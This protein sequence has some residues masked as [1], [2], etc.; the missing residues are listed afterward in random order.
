MARTNAFFWQLLIWMALWCAAPAAQGG[1]SY[2]NCTN[3]ITSVPA[4]IDTPGTWCFNQD[5]STALTSGN[6]ITVSADDVTL[7]CNDFKLD[8]LA[9]GAATTANGIGGN[10]NRLNVTVRRCNIRGFYFG[11][12]LVGSGGGMHR[13]EDNRFD[14]NTYIGLRVEGDGSVVQRNRIFHTGGTTANANASITGLMVL[15]SVDVLDNTVSGVVGLGTG[16]GSTFGI[17]SGYSTSASISGNRVRG[18]VQGT[19]VSSGPAYG[20]YVSDFNRLTLRSNDLVGDAS[21]LSVGMRCFDANAR[22]SD[23]TIKAFAT[24]IS[25]CSND[26]GNVIKP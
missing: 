10:G 4:V 6:A 3:F 12:Y 11:I 24:G 7:D 8:G 25:Y 18:L 2:G 23:N 15:R 5:L 17:Y 13:I 20:I 19:S 1:Q 26:G 14:G 21:A 16:S 9:A 22:A